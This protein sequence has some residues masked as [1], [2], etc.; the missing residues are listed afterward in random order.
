[1][2]VRALA[3]VVTPDVSYGPIAVVCVLARA[4]LNWRRSCMPRFVEAAFRIF[5]KIS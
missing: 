4:P 1:M 3:G 5:Y 2:L